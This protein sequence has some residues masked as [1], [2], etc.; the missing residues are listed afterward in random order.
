[1]HNRMKPTSHRFHYKV[2]MFYIDLDEIDILKKKLL[3]FSH[4][5]FNYFS[6]KD[7]E[8]LQL[9]IDRPDRSKST[10]GHIC[11][12]L[13]ENSIAEPPHKIML[14]TNLNILGYNFNPVSF[15][16]CFNAA[17]QPICCVAE[18][19]NTFREMKPYLITSENL[20]VSTF[21]LNTTKYFYVSPFIEHDTNF[22]FNLV[23]PNEKLNIKIDDYKNG[24]R[25]FIST[26]TGTKKN[27]NNSNLFWYS[28]RFPFLTIRIIVL[29]HW[30]AL[31]LW[32]KKIT[33][34]K[35]AENKH[36]QRDV[37]RKYEK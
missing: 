32:T 13:K 36:L 1:M 16:Y 9:P 19:S 2:F 25:F 20:N 23:V 33:Y 10:K 34:L 29:I 27:L 5:K 8:H 12:Y 15:Y 30:Q 7:S 6:F 11:D 22:D 18:V 21:H 14:L 24:E 17:N 4:N 3:F 37:F 35:K 26:L 28:V 31:L